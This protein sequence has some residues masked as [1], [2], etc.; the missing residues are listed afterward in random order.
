MSQ[1]GRKYDAFTFLEIVSALA[2]L[3]IGILAVITL[4]PVGIENSKRA[5]ERTRASQLAY[6]ELQ[7]YRVLGY[8]YTTAQ[9][10]RVYRSFVTAFPITNPADPGFTADPYFQYYLRHGPYTGA[11]AGTHIEEITVTA[12]WPSTQTDPARRRELKMSTLIAER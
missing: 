4:F 11:T 5:S 10:D 1:N 3:A 9:A 7:H 6:S 12:V 2:V 8:A